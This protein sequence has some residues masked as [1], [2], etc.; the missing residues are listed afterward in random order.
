[1][2]PIFFSSPAEFRAW[3]EEHHAQASELWVGFYKKGSGRA[4]I[5]WPEAVDQALCYGGCPLGDRR[6][7]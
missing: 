5:T 4:S 3:L 1:M 6:R 7:A 2:E